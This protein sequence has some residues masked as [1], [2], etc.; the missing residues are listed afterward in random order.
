MTHKCNA[1][2]LLLKERVSD[3]LNLACDE[4]VFYCT[5]CL[6]ATSTPQSKL[7]HDNTCFN[8]F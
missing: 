3:Y 8:P 6:A 4:R 5:A 2:T 1:D 7:C